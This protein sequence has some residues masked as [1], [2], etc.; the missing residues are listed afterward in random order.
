MRTLSVH[1]SL[2]PGKK[3]G[4]VLVGLVFAALLAAEPA[5]AAQANDFEPLW[6]MLSDW[7][8]GTLG[9]VISISFLL[10]G[11]G[12]GVIRGSI[13]GAISCLAASVALLMAPT[14]INSLFGG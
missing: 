10:V 4:G 6:T 1:G 2:L 7:C 8:S 12:V 5:W 3:T 14:I 13:I 11:L 9:K